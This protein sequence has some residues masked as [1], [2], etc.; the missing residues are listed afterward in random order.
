MIDTCLKHA[1]WNG[2]RSKPPTHS[3]PYLR[4]V[5]RR[6]FDA[7]FTLAARELGS[8]GASGI[9]W[10]HLVSFGIMWDQLGPSE[11]IRNQ[12]GSRGNRLGWPGLILRL[13][14]SGPIWFHLGPSGIMWEQL[15]ST[16]IIWH[17]LGS[18]GI[19]WDHAGWSDITSDI[20]RYLPPEASW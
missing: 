3:K 18:S 12:L 10:V 20:I 7:H 11:G 17:H 8:L 16:R 15:G 6:R 1:F 5:E 4:M 2:M 9:I 14:S 13:R 19:I